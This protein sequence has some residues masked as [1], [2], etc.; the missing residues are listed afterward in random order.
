M[1]IESLRLKTGSEEQKKTSLD[2][3]KGKG[4]KGDVKAQGGDR[5]LCL[6][7]E[8]SYNEYK[9]AGKGLCVDRFMP[10]ITTSGLNYS[11]LRRGD[12]F[13]ING[14]VIEITDT[15]KKCF[16][17]CEFVRNGETCLIKK[18][19][20]FAKILESGTVETGDEIKR[21]SNIELN[22]HGEPDPKR[23]WTKYEWLFLP[24]SWFV[25][26]GGLFWMAALKSNALLYVC[27]II[28]ALLGIWL[29]FFRN[30]HKKRKRMKYSYEITDNELRI[31]LTKKDEL[32][33]RKLPVEN[34]SYIGYSIR[35]DG[36][37]TLYFNFP[38]DYLDL[39][40]L[41]M[42]NSGIGTFDETVF[43]FYELKD[44]EDL[45]EQLTV[46]LGDDIKT[47]KI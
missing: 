32:N 1:R 5:Q 39:F 47:E 28:L 6:A 29:I 8:R 40:R 44:A 45:L 22:W 24:L 14:I 31:I 18:N 26:F 16:P 3:E 27:A 15:E 2:L 46:L 36:S 37:G 42:A 7:D 38:N 33:V 43:A 25:F 11:L 20:A 10:N 12:K 34:I 17:E 41:I 35:K 13:S 21:C 23:K 19:C 30:H 9:E 4:V